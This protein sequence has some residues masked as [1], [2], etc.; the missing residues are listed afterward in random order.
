M[1]KIFLQHQLKDKTS[2]NHPYYFFLTNNTLPVQK[3]KENIRPNNKIII[4][5]LFIK[6]GITIEP[7]HTC[8]ISAQIP[9]ILLILALKI[10]TKK[11]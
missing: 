4:S 1:P 11:Y 7:K 9:E 2:K 6:K 8:P 10:L 5:N 3:I